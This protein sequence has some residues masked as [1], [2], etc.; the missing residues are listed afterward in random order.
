MVAKIPWLGEHVSVFC[1]MEL[2]LVSLEG[3]AVSS[4]ES[5]GFIWFWVGGDLMLNVVFLFC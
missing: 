1:W 5:W 3:N 2:V 4:S